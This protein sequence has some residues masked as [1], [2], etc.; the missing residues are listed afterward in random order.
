MINNTKECGSCFFV[1]NEFADGPCKTCREYN[2]Y[3]PMSAFLDAAYKDN[4]IDRPHHYQLIDGMEVRDILEILAD[5]LNYGNVP[6]TSL[7]ISDYVQMMQ[8][9]MRFMGKNG[10]EDLKKAKYYL[11]QLIEAYSAFD[12]EED[13]EVVDDE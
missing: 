2:K 7:F 6:A 5:K 9:L 13:L 10:V 4:S 1:S 12:D 8:Y 3:V 11:D